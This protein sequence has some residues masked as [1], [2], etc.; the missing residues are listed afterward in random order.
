MAAQKLVLRCFAEGAG[1]KWEAIC[2]DFDIAVQ[3]SSLREVKETLDDMV[4]SYLEAAMNESGER[5]A[6]LLRRKAP[7]YVRMRYAI[8][9]FISSMFDNGNGRDKEGFITHRMCPA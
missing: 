2:I 9:F 8:A 4:N 6:A 3:G 7:L 5:R 1:G